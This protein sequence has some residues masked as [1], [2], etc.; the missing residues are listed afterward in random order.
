MTSRRRVWRILVPLLAIVLLGGA[1]TAWLANRGDGLRELLARHEAEGLGSKLADLLVDAPAVDADVQER[2]TAWCVRHAS[3]GGLW[4]AEKDEQDLLRGRDLPPARVSDHEAFR[5]AAE[6]LAVLLESES[7]RFDVLATAQAQIEGTTPRP[8]W[9][10]P[11]EFPGQIPLHRAARWYAL[12]AA[13]SQDPEPALRALDRLLEASARPACQIEHMFLASR[14]LVRDRAYLRLAMLGGNSPGRLRLWLEEPPPPIEALADVLRADRLYVIAP[15]AHAHLD[16]TLEDQDASYRRRTR[17]LLDVIEDV[18]H[19][20]VEQEGE[21]AA[22]LE[23]TAEFERI[24]RGDRPVRHLDDLA[25]RQPKGYVGIGVEGFRLTVLGNRYGEALHRAAR[26]CVRALAIRRST[27]EFPADDAAFRRALG[28]GAGALDGGPWAFR[29]RYTCWA[30][31]RIR[32]DID[33]G[34]STPGTSWRSTPATSYRGASRSPPCR[35]TG[36]R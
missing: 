9:I 27:G 4:M 17:D 24:L 12:E 21:S 3:V 6:E 29:L 36:P 35:P 20:N 31:N 33:P 23:M 19:R 5:P 2:L 15:R 7:L 14:A 16:G 26:L 22:H 32:V 11:L 18:Y 25:R 30:P 28:A 10:P 1:I 13:R 34:R 8:S